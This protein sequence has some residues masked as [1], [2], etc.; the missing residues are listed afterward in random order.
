MMIPVRLPFSCQRESVW[1]ENVNAV[2]RRK[3]W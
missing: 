1:G 3:Q 2:R